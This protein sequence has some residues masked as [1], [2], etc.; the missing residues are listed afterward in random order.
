MENQQALP[1]V[2]VERIEKLCCLKEMT[3]KCRGPVREKN[4]GQLA[5]GLPAW[6]ASTTACLTANGL[7]GWPA[8][9]QAS[10]LLVLGRDLLYESFPNTINNF[11]SCAYW[12]GGPANRLLPG[13]PAKK[14]TFRDAEAHF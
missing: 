3:K 1:K 10:N 2:M 7:A 4:A 11:L 5:G 13:M 9:G 14:R 8:C 6:P 12:C